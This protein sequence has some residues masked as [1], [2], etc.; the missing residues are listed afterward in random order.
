MD[1]YAADEEEK[2]EEV[3]QYSEFI[4][5]V[6]GVAKSSPAQMADIRSGD[7]ILKAGSVT[8]NSDDPF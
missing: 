7:E 8:A 3:D 2:D 5:I 6:T 4:A 1:I